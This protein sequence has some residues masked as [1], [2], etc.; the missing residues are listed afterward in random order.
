MAMRLR[1]HCLVLY[2]CG[3]LGVMQLM[4]PRLRYSNTHRVRHGLVTHR[5][6]RQRQLI[7]ATGQ[8]HQATRLTG[9]PSRQLR[10]QSAMPTLEHVVLGRCTQAPAE[11]ACIQ[12]AQV[13]VEAVEVFCT[14]STLVCCACLCAQWPWRSGASWWPRWP[15]R[16]GPTCIRGRHTGVVAPTSQERSRSC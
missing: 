3:L 11:S 6:L 4:G 1:V 14:A 12:F 16:A 5:L 8:T 13:L 2:A 9:E 15:R 10:N 7:L